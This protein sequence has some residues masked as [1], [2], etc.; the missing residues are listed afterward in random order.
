MF[1]IFL[2]YEAVSLTC[3]LALCQKYCTVLICS[4]GFKPSF[5][6]PKMMAAIPHKYRVNVL[7][8]SLTFKFLLSNVIFQ[9]ELHE[10]IKLYFS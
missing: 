7:M 8:A 1:H 2:P 9:F 5:F 10:F 6:P 3:V 4:P